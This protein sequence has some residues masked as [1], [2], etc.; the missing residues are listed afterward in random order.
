MPEN[1]LNEFS[2]K[3]EHW[4]ICIIFLRSWVSSSTG[5]NDS[6]VVARCRGVP[7][8]MDSHIDWPPSA[9]ASL[10][11]APR[12]ADIFRQFSDDFLVV[13]FNKFISIGPFTY[14]FLVWPVLYTVTFAAFHYQL[15]P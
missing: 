11:E 9:A 15:A 6:R 13:V 10:N 5:Q 8:Y 3:G 1:Q 7:C 2:E 14:P 4:L 12:T